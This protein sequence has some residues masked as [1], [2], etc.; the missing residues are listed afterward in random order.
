MTRLRPIVPIVVNDC[1][2]FKRFDVNDLL[3]FGKLNLGLPEVKVI[4][5]NSITITRSSFVKVSSPS[6]TELR[7]ILGGETGDII[8]ISKNAPSDQF[9]ITSTGNIKVP[10]WLYASNYFTA[11]LVYDGVFWRTIGFSANQ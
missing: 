11:G 7:N 2:E 9:Q 5:G 6:Y 1:P 10:Y 4:T 8:I 3:N